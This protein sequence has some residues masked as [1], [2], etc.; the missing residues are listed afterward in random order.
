M[1]GATVVTDA[2]NAATVTVSC[3]AGQVAVGGGGNGG[4]IG[5]GFRSLAASFP[6]VSGSTPD[7]WTA[8]FSGASAGNTVY[9]S[10]AS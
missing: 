8:R 10:C 9:V 4:A 1:T 7:G 2:A 5:G 3:P 6:T